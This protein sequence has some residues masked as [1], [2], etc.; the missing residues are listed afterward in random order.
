MDREPAELTIHS[1]KP[2]GR[3]AKAL[4]EMGIDVL[5]VAEDEGNVD[6]YI[7]SKRLAV[8][9][10]TGGGFLRG[11][12]DKTL[13][14][15]AI[16]LREHFE[17]A[18]LIIEGQVNYEYT[19]FDPQATRGALSSM[20][21]QYG[22][23][24]LSTAD[25]EQTVALIAMMA[26]QEQVGIPAISLIPKRKATGLADMQRRLIEMLPGCGMALA[27][28]LLQRFGGVQ[29]VLSASRQELLACTGIGPTKADEIDA[30][31]RGEYRS[32]DTEKH[33]EDAIEAEPSLLFDT[34]VELIDRQHYIFS[35]SKERHI[36]DLV[37]VDEAAT[38][39]VLVELKRGKLAA[40]HVR[41]LRRYLDNA[42]KSSL[43]GG[44]LESGME[45]R[46]VLATVEPCDFQPKDRDISARIVD[47]ERAID[48]LCRLRRERIAA[49]QP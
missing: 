35:E 13:F 27:R 9:R 38:R 7:L 41:Q 18:I 16:Y 6:R 43:L 36:V 8:E 32:V 48:V 5:P 26:R 3:P 42:H 20:V 28:D 2:K 47:K 34:P 24:V 29:Q 31:L 15:S 45:L 40:E 4:T 12:M 44:M 30:V 1:T 39:I 19:A 23:C 10:R 46:G 21:L 14:T 37:F 17:L 33:L 11:I 22:L 49:Q 25:L